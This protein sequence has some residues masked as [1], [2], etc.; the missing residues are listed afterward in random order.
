MR[1]ALPPR[2]RR[3]R[4]EKLERMAGVPALHGWSDADVL[5]LGRAGDLIDASPGEQ[6]T[7]GAHAGQWWW[8]VL[9]GELELVVDGRP[10]ATVGPG[11]WLRPDPS[12]GD[13]LRTASLR[14]S[15]PAAVLTGRVADLIQLAKDRPRVL[16]LLE[17]LPSI[18]PPSVEATEARRP[19]TGAA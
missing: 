9:R 15:A 4:D 10:A 3:R 6:L 19:H 14:A 18:D 1:L 17:Q 5:A 8:L 12:R 11:R 16:R 2:R 13:Q 7:A